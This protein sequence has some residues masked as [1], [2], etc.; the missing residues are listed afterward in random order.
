MLHTTAVDSS[1]GV[2]AFDAATVAVSDAWCASL[3]A[4]AGGGVDGNPGVEAFFW[5]L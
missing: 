2:P 4:R 1:L 5:A 3:G